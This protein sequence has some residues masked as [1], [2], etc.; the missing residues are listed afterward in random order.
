MY[1]ASV[2]NNFAMVHAALCSKSRR[3][4]FSDVIITYTMDPLLTTRATLCS[5]QGVY[6][7]RAREA[8]E[9]FQNGSR[10]E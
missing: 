9:L 8:T 5:M 10:C 7:A 6:Q 3:R 2:N 4:Y 1:L